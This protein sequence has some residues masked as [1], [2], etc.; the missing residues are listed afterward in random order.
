MRWFERWLNTQVDSRLCDL[1]NE[2]SVKVAVE[3]LPGTVFVANLMIGLARLAQQMTTRA[4][5]FVAT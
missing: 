1:I 2:P 5:R 4:H 3:F